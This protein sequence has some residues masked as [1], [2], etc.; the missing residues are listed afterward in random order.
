MPEHMVTH[1]G[2]GGPDAWMPRQRGLRI[3]WMVA[4]GMTLVFV[5]L[6]VLT[7]RKPGVLDA[8]E[9]A[10][11]LIRLMGMRVLY[12]AHNCS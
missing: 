7:P 10:T 4:A 9:A 11:Q 12:G 6:S 2:F 5:A 3:G 1:I 8:V